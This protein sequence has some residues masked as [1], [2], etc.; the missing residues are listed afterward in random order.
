[1]SVLRKASSRP[2]NPGV[3]SLLEPVSGARAL[4]ER[5]GVMNASRNGS[6]CFLPSN[7]VTDAAD[8]VPA[9]QSGGFWR[10]LIALAA[11]CCGCLEV[12][13]VSLVSV[14]DSGATPG[15]AGGGDSLAPVL[16]W[17]GEYILFTSAANN[18]VVMTNNRPL[19]AAPVPRLNVYVRQS[20]TT[21]LVSVNMAGTGGGNGDSVGTAISSNGQF[22]LFESL[23]S[24]L[25]PDDTNGCSDVF[26]RDM[27]EGTTLLVSVSTNGGAANGPSWDS[28]MTEDGRFVAFVSAANNLVPDDTNGIP[29]VFVRDL[30][31]NTTVLVSV[32]ARSSFP[33]YGFVRSDAPAI[34]AD[35]RYVAFHS[36]A[37]N[38]VP[39]VTTGTNIYVRDWVAGITYWASANA[40]ALL[41]TLMGTTN[42]I[43]SNPLLSEDGQIVAFRVSPATGSTM[44]AG[45]ILR[46]NLQTGDTDVVATN[47]NVVLEG[48]LEHRPGLDMTPDGRWI[49]FVANTNGTSG[50]NTCIRVW[51]ALTG[52]TTLA[53][54]GLG[55]FIAADSICGWPTID[56]T[57][58]FV[59]FI[60]SGTNT[61]TTNGPMNAYHLY[62]KDMQSG[63][64]R[65]VNRVTNAVPLGVSFSALSR[66]A[67]GGRYLAFQAP[68]GNLVPGDSNRAEDIFLCDLEA[69]TITLV[70]ARDPGLPSVTPAGPSGNSALAVS[71]DGR[72]VLFSSQADN[73][74]L[75]DTNRCMDLFVRDVFTG[76][77]YLVNVATNGMSPRTTNSSEASISADG[78]YVAFS[79]PAIEL[80]RGDTNRVRDV[81]VRDIVARTTTLVSVSTNPPG[82]GNGESLR[83]V[84]SADGQRVLFLSFA[85]NL[86]SGTAFNTT[87]LF[88]RNLQAARTIALTTFG[89]HTAAMT[90]D[91]RRVAFV[92]AF[93][94]LQ[95]NLY[96]WD[97]ELETR[98]Y[99]NQT[100][101]IVRVAISPEGGRLAYATNGQLFVADLTANTNWP[102]GGI[103]PDFR[104]GLRFSAD[105]RFLTFASK[106]PLISP[107]TNATY[108]VFLYDLQ[109]RSN[110]LVSHALGLPDAANGA[111]DSPDISPDG[112]FIVFRSTASNLVSSDSNGASDVF[113]YDS[114]LDTTILLSANR[115]DGGSGDSWSFSPQFTRDG[116]RVLFQSWASDLAEFDFNQSGDVFAYAMFYADIAPGGLP[117]AGPVL[118]WPVIAGKTYHVQYRDDLTQNQW[119][120]AGSNVT[121]VG[122]RAYFTDPAPAPGKRFYRIVAH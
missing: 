47:V 22:A 12:G 55:A 100:R 40:R 61:I 6:S 53:S 79:S 28:T 23:A 25:V 50:R 18:L 66:L 3:R 15:M 117:E 43:F 9:R 44:N 87:N 102:V 51:D 71:A 77:N 97:A 118:S 120:N 73:V 111:S 90:P 116:R 19:P 58:R 49:A 107:D 13:A 121:I 112:R 29:D 84:I 110:R 99:T 26:V 32:G 115:F 114:F 101:G 94:D 106:T 113:L 27:H 103:T 108:D 11:L 31:S 2:P 20:T 78:R 80:V 69:S 62:V 88:Y 30:A 37:T 39:G 1:M 64:T 67:G 82:P 59:A 41:L 60:S 95:T 98:V 91:G 54:D 122:E 65:W 119:Q 70:S 75:N 7:A 16:S 57:G 5:G 24:D 76:S 48:E 92:G 63:L 105:G 10:G 4:Q 36:T 81:F 35:G 83:P 89:V 42:A 33:Y 72:F 68:D 8:T 56:P 104:S 46:Y 86:A 34:S 14:A 21:A 45:L 96:V 17:N 93:G 52:Q 85:N 109:T 38:L 74:T